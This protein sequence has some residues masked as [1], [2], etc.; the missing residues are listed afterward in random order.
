MKVSI[1]TA[2][3]AFGLLC[4]PVK[5]QNQEYSSKGQN[6]SITF[7]G[8]P[9]IENKDHIFIAD[10]FSDDGVVF[11]SVMSSDT[12]DEGDARDNLND[13]VKQA[14]SV[15]DSPVSNCRASTWSGDPTEF[16]D[17][18]ITRIDG[19]KAVGYEWMCMH[20]GYIYMVS[21]T[22][23]AT[24][25]DGLMFYINSFRF[26]QAITPEPPDNRPVA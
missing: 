6:F 20:D 9:E 14:T 16:C 22:T 4:V 15:T 11:V 3:V 1:L 23:T 2:L 7:P 5:A 25:P 19:K 21:T 10:S 8:Q 26:L 13:Y 12:R 24:T 17:I 18:V